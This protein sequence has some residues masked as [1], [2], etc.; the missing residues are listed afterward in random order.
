M[1]SLLVLACLEGAATETQPQAPALADC[2]V[3]Q[4]D[5]LPASVQTVDLLT[6][7]VRGQAM[8]S[9]EDLA[10]MVAADTRGGLSF[11]AGTPGVLVVDASS[12]TPTVIG[13]HQSFDLEGT[14]FIHAF[15]DGTVF[16]SGTNGSFL[17]D[18]R[19]PTAPTLVG[20]VNIPALSDLVETVNGTLA[21]TR[22]G[23]LVDWDTG[24]VYASD[25]GSTRDLEVVDNVAMVLEREWSLTLVDLDTGDVTRMRTAAP[26]TAAA[27]TSDV[28]YVALGSAGVQLFDI[29]NPSVPTRIW[30]HEPPGTATDLAVVDDTLWVAT[31]DGVAMMDITLPRIPQLVSHQPTPE[32]ALALTPSWGGVVV[33][34]WSYLHQMQRGDLA[35]ILELSHR[36]MAVAESG[37]L[38]LSNPSTAPLSLLKVSGSEGLLLSELPDVLEGGESVELSVTLD[39][40]NEGELC[41]ATNDAA[42]PLRR[43]AV[44]HGE[45]I[46][47]AVGQEAP[48]FELY[49]LNGVSYSL[50]AER[51]QPV[52]LV[53]FAT[54][55][56]ICA[57]ELDDIQSM[58]DSLGAEV[59]LVASADEPHILREFVEDR[60]ITLP[61]LVDEGGEIYAQ[62]QQTQQF[63]TLFPQNWVVGQDGTIVYAS[64]HYEPDAIAASLK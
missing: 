48:G 25:L 59:W 12:G 2:E 36:A 57:P 64:N 26:P 39:A 63:Q 7:D 22:D 1:L 16:V 51:G 47:L 62:W 43:V 18:V 5:A 28:L 34:D 53:F 24:E 29:S 35:P 55:C 21:L 45:G 27:R 50:E 31:I 10:H 41:I 58:A 52:V 61:V 11:V 8:P 6:E 33:A 23:Q 54:W 30:T 20:K 44:H 49:D 14:D 40:A 56:P 15:G 46:E 19:T 4:L 37:T 38:V 9:F 3:P 32:F 17:L 60:N 42:A 13:E